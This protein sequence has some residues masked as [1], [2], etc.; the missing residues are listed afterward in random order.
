MMKRWVVSYVAVD[1]TVQDHK[2]R[3]FFR[4][5]ADACAHRMASPLYDVVMERSDGS[6]RS[7]VHR[8]MDPKDPG[9]SLDAFVAEMRKNR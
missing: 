9:F 6:H 3:F 7:V 1:G 5:N 2:D 4:F 8:H